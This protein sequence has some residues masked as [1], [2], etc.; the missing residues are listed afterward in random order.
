SSVPGTAVEYYVAEYQWIQY[1]PIWRRF[2]GLLNVNVAYG[3]AFGDTTALPPYRQFYGGGPDTVR[4]F[5]ES[6]MGPKDDIGNPYGGNL[7]TV[8]RAELLLPLPQKWQTSA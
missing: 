1:I 4:G 2:T 3:A 6:R 5:R 7:I 8:A